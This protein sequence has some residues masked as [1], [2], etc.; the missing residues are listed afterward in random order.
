MKSTR[1]Q[2]SG[3]V[4]AGGKSRRMGQDKGLI[5]LRGQKMVEYATQALEGICSRISIISNQADYERLPY[6]IYPDLVQDKGPL[7]GICTALTQSRTNINIILSCDS[8]NVSTELLSYLIDQLEDYE[9]VVPYF[10]GR[11]YPLTAVYTKSCLDTF[12]ESL[13][14]DELKVKAIIKKLNTKRID[15]HEGMSFYH[16]QL[17]SNINTLEEL[18]LHEN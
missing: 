15:I 11:I 18:E 5:E 12:K 13:D 3:F 4:L 10:E 1:E 7:A 2:I 16:E 17:M 8:P 6:N 14:E 9:A